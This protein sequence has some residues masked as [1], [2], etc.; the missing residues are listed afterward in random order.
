MP[1]LRLHSESLAKPTPLAAQHREV[2]A[3][4]SSP[5][6]R[7]PAQFRPH[8]MTIALVTSVFI[9]LSGGVAQ[10]LSLED[11]LF[12]GVQVI[13]LSNL[14]A[15]QEISLGRQIHQN[16]LK[17]GTRLNNNPALNRY[18]DEIGQR[19]V[20][21]SDRPNLT[22]HFFVVQDKAVNAYATMGGYV[23]VTTGLIETAD[24]E[25]QLASVL[26]HEW[27]H[28]QEKHL[29]QQIQKASI[30][31]GLV[32][33]ALGTDRNVLANIGVELLVKRPQGRQDEY[34]ADREGLKILTQA[35]YDPA[36]MPAFMQ[37]LLG[38]GSPPTFLSTHPAVPDRLQALEVEVAN[39]PSNGCDR[40]PPPVAC[41]LDKVAYQNRIARR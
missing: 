30:A 4:R 23:Y 38:G 20:S 24:N 32:S 5:Q 7:S 1:A 18:I 27:G 2:G 37:K 19:I 16:L 25:A 33:S 26:A 35:G 40:N 13:Q 36:A 10:A 17:Q 6:L 15:P 3:Q 12:R 39:G 41:G 14:S 29:L 28:I 34:E 9:G 11:L 22:P 21:A 31:Q 8:R